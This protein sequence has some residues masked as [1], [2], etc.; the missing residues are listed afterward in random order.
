MASDTDAARAR[1]L[2]ARTELALELERLE[3]SARAA[4]DIPAKVRRSPAKAAAIAGGTG[5]LVLG[6][7]KRLFKRA[8]RAVVGPEQPLPERMLPKEIE[9]TLG[10]LGRDG[11]RVRGTLER[12]FA[13]YVREA[14]GKRGPDL[15][16][17]V[18]GAVA[19]PILTRLSKSAAEWF[20]R[21]DE[22]GFQAQLERLRD[23]R[24]SS[25]GAAAARD[26]DSAGR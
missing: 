7:P 12:D 3:A 16:S 8:K 5:F 15:A 1:V 11:D 24:R 4:A 23:S 26:A 19:K 20:V 18:S 25:S 21:T 2:A 13:A 22:E 9:K 17:L 14:Q 10:K 6:G